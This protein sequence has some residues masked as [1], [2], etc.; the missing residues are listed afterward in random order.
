MALSEPSFTI[1]IEEEYLLIDRETLN[2]AADPPEALFAECEDLLGAQ[3]AP[4]FLR[5]Q[6]EIGTRVCST[7]QEA[8]ADLRRLRK[9]VSGVA[10]KHGL[11][12]MAASTHPFAAWGEQKRTEKDRYAMLAEDLQGVVRRLVISG[13]HVHV[14]IDDDDLRIDLMNQV[15]YF[16]PH[17]L[18]LSTSS[19]FWQ[20]KDT[21]LRSYRL[22]VWDELPRTGLP[23][24]FESFGEYN[25]HVQMLIEAGIIDEP[26]KIWW[27]IRPSARFPTLEMR[28]CDLCPRLADTVAI[29]A[30]YRCILRMLWRLRRQNQRWRR[31]ANMLIREN[32]WRAQRYGC[33][34][35]LID[36]GIRRM[37]PFADL[38]EELL[39][40]TRPDAEHF[41]CQSEIEHSR[42][43]LSHGTS[44]RRQVQTYE[45]GLAEGLDHQ[46]AIGT[47]V[48]QLIEET[49]AG[50]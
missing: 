1:G 20:G 31:Y 38:L 32:R 23:E 40:M 24:Q 5:A 45:A 50:L 13:M 19:P 16:L 44:A 48:T 47:V 26:T 39:E 33:D 34:G 3:V 12:I 22:A 6:I 29:A 30:L 14:G 7:M 49:V 9:T 25:R 37:V 10:E 28:I 17:L 42:A 4:E 43:I 27:D 2:L 41:G 8:A 21:G 18:A 46:A 15:S 11:A 35:E 36:F